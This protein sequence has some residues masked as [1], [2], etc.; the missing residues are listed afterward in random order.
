MSKYHEAGQIVSWSW[1]EQRL[2]DALAVLQ[3]FVTALDGDP[4]FLETALE[5]VRIG[6]DQVLSGK[7]LEPGPTEPGE[8]HTPPGFLR[9]PG[10]P[11]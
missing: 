10:G 2:K 1:Q 9:G 8:Q 6:A 7:L 4:E 5:T 11:Q 3:E